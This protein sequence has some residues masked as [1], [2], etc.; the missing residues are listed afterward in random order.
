M[1]YTRENLLLVYKPNKFFNELERSSQ[2]SRPTLH[3]ALWR[4]QK[5]GL[6]ERENQIIR[7]TEKGLQKIQPYTA[8]KLL[9]E[10]RLMVTFDIPEARADLRQRIR[11]LLREWRFKQVQKSVWVSEY[12][13]G[14][15]LIKAVEEM[16]A[17][18]Y[19]QIFECARI[20]PKL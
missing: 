3:N 5:Q 11:I 13:Y 18:K 1:P 17:E 16:K 8:K 12:D 20:Y 9:R 2:Y 6:I 15:M 14:K 10:A 7:I 4:A 19:V